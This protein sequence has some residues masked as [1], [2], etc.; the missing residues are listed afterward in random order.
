[1]YYNIYI[2]EYGLPPQLNDCV[3]VFMVLQFIILRSSVCTPFSILI[4]L[5][6]NLLK[7][8]LKWHKPTDLY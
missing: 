4:H 8:F 2:S 3:Y 7:S 1:M 5:F 6:I